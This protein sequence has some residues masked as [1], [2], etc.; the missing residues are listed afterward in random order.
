MLAEKKI[1]GVLINSQHN[2]AWL[3]AGGNNGVDSSRENG[4][5][6]LLIRNDGRKFILASKIEIREFSKKKFP[7]KIS[8]RLSLAGKTKNQQPIF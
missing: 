5:A 2:F 4:A 8:S 1:G 3:T 7:S 6:S